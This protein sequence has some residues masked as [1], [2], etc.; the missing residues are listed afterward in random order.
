MSEQ[1]CSKRYMHAHVGGNQAQQICSTVI[2]LPVFPY[3]TSA[4]LS[5][6]VD[7]VKSACEEK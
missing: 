4:E 2:N 5:T 7:V 6:V 1:E 3:I